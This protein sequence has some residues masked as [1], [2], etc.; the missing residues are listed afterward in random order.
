MPTTA[1]DPTRAE[2]NFEA[3][4]ATM[5]LNKAAEEQAARIRQFC[6]RDTPTITN[7]DVP[8]S[9]PQSSLSLPA[10]QYH[11]ELDPFCSSNP[12]KFSMAE[13]RSSRAIPR[14]KQS[15]VLQSNEATTASYELEKADFDDTASSTKAT[16]LGEA[17]TER[18][19]SHRA[20]TERDSTEAQ[21]ATTKARQV[22]SEK[23]HDDGKETHT[24]E[25]MSESRGQTKAQGMD[26]AVTWGTVNEPPRPPASKHTV[27]TTIPTK[28]GGSRDDLNSAT[29]LF[30]TEFARLALIES[31]FK[32]K[33]ADDAQAGASQRSTSRLNTWS[34]RST[35]LQK[36][37]QNERRRAKQPGQDDDDSEEE[38]NSSGRYHKDGQDEAKSLQSCKVFACPFWSQNYLQHNRHNN[39]LGYN[40]RSIS[41][42]KQHL[43][44]IHETSVRCPRCFQVFEKRLQLD[45]H[46]RETACLASP[47]DNLVDEEIKPDVWPDV[48][49][50]HHKLDPETHWFAIFQVLFPGQP[51]PWSPYIEGQIDRKINQKST[52]GSSQAFRISSTAS[53]LIA[54]RP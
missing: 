24:A 45:A 34:N 28:N 22:F 14:H 39:C 15:D 37:R 5:S 8:R 7:W 44:R 19:A 32:S 18:S 1:T 38:D 16:T 52:K 23:G 25:S 20:E 41:A 2:H 29:A 13:T 33:A 51:T 42:L 4:I 9:M 43:R 30:A 35:D 40:L 47:E 48:N 49:K 36:L 27:S 10:A 53:L 31:T 12:L 17:L 46:L 54:S 11:A 6:R 26:K 21:F 50:R 3:K